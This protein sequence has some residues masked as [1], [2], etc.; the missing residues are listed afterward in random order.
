MALRKEEGKFLKF[1]SERGGYPR[2][3]G[4]FPQKT[5]DSNPGENYVICMHAVTRYIFTF[6]ISK[7]LYIK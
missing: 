1:L 7:E 6:K 4:G 3:G 5:G 2:T